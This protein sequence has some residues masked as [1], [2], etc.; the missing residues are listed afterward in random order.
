MA[1]PRSRP[2]HYELTADSDA[3][4]FTAERGGR[5]NR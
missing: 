1:S 5:L 3:L 2:E 4:V